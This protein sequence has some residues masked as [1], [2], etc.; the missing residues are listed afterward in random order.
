MAKKPFKETKVG[1]FLKDK[2]GDLLDTAGSLITG[3][4]VDAA[5]QIKDLI[6]GSSNLSPEEKEVALK[7]L[8][9]DLEAFRI[10]VDDRKD[11][12][13]RE[14]QISTS[15]EATWL[16][17]NT[18]SIIALIFVVFTCTLY[19]LVLPRQL[20]ASENITFSVVSSVTSITTL[21]IGYYF[22]SSRSSAVKDAT[23]GRLTK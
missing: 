5:G 18:G 7:Y 14:I 12:R 11:A 21:I 15:P 6:T 17:K 22:G 16:N 9:Q 23:I 20:N 19:I 1:K 8:E 3:N 10:E 2:G 4:W 13:N